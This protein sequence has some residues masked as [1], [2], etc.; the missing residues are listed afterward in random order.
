VILI[1]SV[2]IHL[3]LSGVTSFALPETKFVKVRFHFLTAASMKMTVFWDTVP[4]SLVKTD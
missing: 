1:K 3:F 2:H 4:C